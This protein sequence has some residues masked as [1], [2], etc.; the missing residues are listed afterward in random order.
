MSA[1]CQSAC[2]S[3][4]TSDDVCSPCDD[5][6]FPAGVLDDMLAVASD[7]L[8]EWSGRRFPGS[9]ADTV[10]PCTRATATGTPHFWGDQDGTTD[11][12]LVVCGCQRGRRC[13]CT[14]LDEITLGGYPVTS[15]TE[16]K[17]DGAVLDPARYRVDDFRWLVR[18][19]DADGTNPGWP[20]CQNLALDPDQPDTFEVTFT[21]GTPP[22]RAGV[23]AA[24]A[25]GCELA[26]ACQPETIGKCRLPRK[27]T[28]VVRQGVTIQ[29]I[30]PSRLFQRD[31]RGH[32]VVGLTEV[33]AFLSAYTRT[34]G[35]QGRAQVLSPDIGRRVRR[36]GT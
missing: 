2:S 12:G 19:P 13:G 22:P 6:S 36:A 8:F 29:L 18:L 28:Q 5:Y 25:L 1:P 9:C 24:A 20:C 15:I 33:D 35:G 14:T 31:E 32:L 17:I 26:L 11:R 4:A 21:Y 10:R 34:A 16:V 23:S 30:D 7:L 3:W 27:V